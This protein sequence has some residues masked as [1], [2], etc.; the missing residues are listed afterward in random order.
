MAKVEPF[1]QYGDRYEDWFE[2]NSYAYRSELEAVRLSLP[3]GVGVEIGSGSG[4]FAYPLGVRFGVDPSMKM[5]LRAKERGIEVICGT[6]EKLPLR[7]SF[8]D[9][10]LMVTTVCFVDDIEASFEEARR[11]LKPS[12]RLVVGFIDKESPIGKAY[13]ENRERSLFYRIARFYSTEEIVGLMKGAGF[14]DFSYMQTIFRSLS[15]MDSI[16][17]VKK[18]YGEGSFVVVSASRK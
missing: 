2:R 17:P 3:K 8:F 7:N 18:G 6:A 13:E 12:G 16:E 9:F 10:A 5:N 11:I 14:S 1:E 15:E 4:R